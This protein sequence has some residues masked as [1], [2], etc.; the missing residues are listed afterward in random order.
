MSK[1]KP[2]ITSVETR[3]L[4]NED[5][6]IHDIDRFYNTDPLDTKAYTGSELYKYI[7]E[8]VQKQRE[9]I[10]LK[11]TRAFRTKIPDIHAQLAT[12]ANF[13]DLQE[14]F[15]GGNAEQLKV[16]GEGTQGKVIKIRYPNKKKEYVLVSKNTT[17]IVK[18]KHRPLNMVLKISIVGGP[19]FARYVATKDEYYLK[20]MEKEMKSKTNETAMDVIGGYWT[21]QVFNQGFT[22]GIAPPMY[23]AER[24]G[25]KSHGHNVMYQAQWGQQMERTLE[26]V[27]FKGMDTKEFQSVLAQVCLVLGAAQRLGNLV[28]NDLYRRN[29]MYE[30]VPVSTMVYY[31]EYVP[32]GKNKFYAVPTYGKLWKLIDLGRIHLKLGDLELTSDRVAD[33]MGDRYD[34]T[35]M[36]V[37]LHTLIFDI[38]EHGELPSKKKWSKPWRRLMNTGLRGLGKKLKG[39]KADRDCIYDQIIGEDGGFADPRVKESKMTPYH[40]VKTFG[41]LD[42]YTVSADSVPKNAL[43]FPLLV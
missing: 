14:I 40:W 9:M 13:D 25:G 5:L 11:Y 17:S 24:V 26:Q 31:E 29:V 41:I 34:S 18:L 7:V 8:F 12:Q 37:D 1:Y 23:Y 33:T 19:A 15:A 42:S 3:D 43:V 6:A 38:M 32:G 20:K 21:T 30:K 22:L 2:H 4:L 35:R 27:L 28:H 36:N 10:V 39:C 16:L